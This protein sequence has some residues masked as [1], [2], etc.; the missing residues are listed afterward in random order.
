MGLPRARNAT[1]GTVRQLLAIDSVGFSL[2]LSQILGF[3]FVEIN[4]T[5]VWC[6]HT[7]T[8]MK[9][10]SIRPTALRNREIR[11]HSCL[12]MWWQENMNLFKF[13]IFQVKPKVYSQLNDLPDTCMFLNEPFL[14]YSEVV[15]TSRVSEHIIS[16][17]EDKKS[18]FGKNPCSK[19]PENLKLTISAETP[20]GWWLG[21]CDMLLFKKD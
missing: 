15:W 9:S 2:L 13:N 21:T 20:A 19:T 7:C 17:L 12:C 18:I 11:T 14:F 4:I 16:N 10:S 6:Q 8:T 5:P 1:L 3:C